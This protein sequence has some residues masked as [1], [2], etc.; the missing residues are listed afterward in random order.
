MN[1]ESSNSKIT[2]R[3]GRALAEEL[4]RTRAHRAIL[5][6]LSGDLGAGKTTFAQG[7][8]KGLGI[9]AKI[10]SPT[11]VVMKRFA[12]PSA[13]KS[14]FKAVFHIDAYRLKRPS[15]LLNIGFAEM[16][17]DP[18]AIILLEWPEKVQRCLPRKYILV[19][20]EHRTTRNQRM[21]TI[22]EI[23]R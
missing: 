18:H 23:K 11:F 8:M 15:E 6:A 9:R 19:R 16:L 14:R 21:L 20:L 2:A 4:L 7:F 1:L 10:Q 22:Q 17:R 12:I 3:V 5:V 13:Y